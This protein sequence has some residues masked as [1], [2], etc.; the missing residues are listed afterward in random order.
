MLFLLHLRKLPVEEECEMAKWVPN[1][2][3]Y[4]DING[5]LS[6]EDKASRAL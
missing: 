4:N 1:H 2:H 6:I 5:I 3:N